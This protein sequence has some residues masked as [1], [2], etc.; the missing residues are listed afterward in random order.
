MTDHQALDSLKSAQPRSLTCAVHNRVLA[1]MRI[2][3]HC[4]SDQR[5]SAGCNSSD[6]VEAVTVN[7]DDIHIHLLLCGWVLDCGLGIE[8]PCL[9]HSYMNLNLTKQ[10]QYF[11]TSRL[12]SRVFFLSS[13]L[14][15]F[16]QILTTFFIHC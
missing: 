3:C 1:P 14:S 10:I 11:S 7:T 2:Q 8:H 6:G 9:R 4:Q 13:L 5:Q 12:C 16:L 15:F